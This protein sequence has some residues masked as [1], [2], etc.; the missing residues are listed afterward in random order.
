MQSKIDGEIVCTEYRDVVPKK[1]G[2]KGP[3]EHHTYLT[4]WLSGWNNDIFHFCNS[5][6]DQSQPPAER[7]SH[8]MIPNMASGRQSIPISYY[9]DIAYRRLR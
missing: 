9:F 4:H 5:E 7:P 1:R 3:I 8:S 6:I 2:A